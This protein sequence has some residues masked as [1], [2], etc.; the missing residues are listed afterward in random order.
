MFPFYGGLNGDAFEEDYDGW[1]SHGSEGPATLRCNR[2]G[3]LPLRWIMTTAGWR[4]AYKYGELK[5]KLHACDN[6][7]TN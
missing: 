4:M 2:C 5:D 6:E 7:R 1:Y 3:Y